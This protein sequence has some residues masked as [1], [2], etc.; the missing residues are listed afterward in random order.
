MKDLAVVSVLEAA[1]AQLYDTA[2]GDTYKAHFVQDGV[3][4][5]N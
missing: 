4:V 5:A 1:I 2:K 3:L